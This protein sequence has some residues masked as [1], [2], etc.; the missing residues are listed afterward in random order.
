MLNY[1]YILRGHLKELSPNTVHIMMLKEL[2]PNDSI[3]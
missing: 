3:N 1:T 2:Y